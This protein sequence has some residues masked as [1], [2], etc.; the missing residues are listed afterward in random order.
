MVKQI[1]LL[2]TLAISSLIAL[3]ESLYVNAKTGNDKNRGSLSQPLKTIAEAAKRINAGMAKEATT[4]ILSEG[5]YPLTETVVFDNNEFSLENRLTIRAEVLPDDVNWN[6]QRMP[7]ITAIITG[8]QTPGDGEESKGF[9]IEASHVTIEG[10]RFTGSPVYYYIDSR[11][12]RRYYPIWRDGKNL[13]D[14]VVTQCLFAGNVDVLPIRVAVIANGDGLVVD[15][16]VFYN[17]QNPVVFWSAQNGTSHHNAMRYC[18]VYEAN[19]SGVWTTRQTG[20][21]F[22]FHHDVIAHSRT[23]WIRDDSSTHRYEIHDCIF[24]GNIKTT[25]N[26]GDKAIDNDFLKM[27]NVQMSGTIDI[28]KDQSKNNYLQLKEGSFGSNLHAGL[29]KK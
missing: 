1:F 24:S 5:I 4:I 14:L 12:A 29:F 3:A 25:G 15:H 21:D 17:C 13:D 8:R 6:P 19:Y 20:D 26:G 16:C 7:V 28:E 11:Q 22:E 10:L 9:D 23:A 2:V 27:E 18:F